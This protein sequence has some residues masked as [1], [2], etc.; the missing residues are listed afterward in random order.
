MEIECQGCGYTGNED[1][2]FHRNP[3]SG[4]Q[5]CPA[6]GD[7]F[8]VEKWLRDRVAK[9]EE[10]I[11]NQHRVHAGIMSE[12]RAIDAGGKPGEFTIAL[13]APIL[14]MIVAAL[15]EHFIEHPGAENFLTWC[16]RGHRVGKFELTLRKVDGKTPAESIGELKEEIEKLKAALAG[17]DEMDCRDYAV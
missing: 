8:P 9:L 1:G 11:E 3:K 6:C 4:E 12:C 16:V 2:D 5:W 13:K 15:E 14:P 7:I 10:A 17:G